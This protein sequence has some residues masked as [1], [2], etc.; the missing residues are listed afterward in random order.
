MKV[1]KWT[2]AS[3][4]IQLMEAW[5]STVGIETTH[6]GKPLK[7]VLTLAR[8]NDEGNIVTMELQMDL[9]ESTEIVDG[10][11]KALDEYMKKYFVSDGKQ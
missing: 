7:C 3:E 8:Y 4:Q 5:L 1:S 6:E 11:D 2:K 10:W 9:N